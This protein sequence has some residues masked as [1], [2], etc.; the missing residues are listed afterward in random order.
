MVTMV[1]TL[2]LQCLYAM[3]GRL[4]E[5]S[6][7]TLSLLP[8]S[9]KRQLLLRLPVVDICS[10]ER[11]EGFRNLDDPDQVW[12]ELQRERV[13]F[14]SLVLRDSDS[15]WSGDGPRPRPTYKTAKDAVLGELAHVFL[16]N[17]SGSRKKSELLTYYMYGVHVCRDMLPVR[18]ASYREHSSLALSGVMSLPHLVWAVPKRF[19]G[20]A[21]SHITTMLSRFMQYCQWYPKIVQLTE[22]LGYLDK[23]S[24][25]LDLLPYVE[26][27]YVSTD[28]PS[29]TPMVTT[30]LQAVVKAAQRS[31][32]SVSLTAYS[33][34]LYSLITVLFTALHSDDSKGPHL[35]RGLQKLELVVASTEGSCYPRLSW[36][37]ESLAQL[38][39]HQ[40]ALE[41]LVINNFLDVPDENDNRGELELIHSSY[42][43]FG[44]FFNFLPHFV[45]K[46]SFKS[47]H[48]T[49][50]RIPCNAMESM[51]T[52]LLNSP[53]SHDQ[54]LDFIGCYIMEKCTKTIT[55]DCGLQQSEEFRL[56]QVAEGRCIAGEHKSL[57]V[58]VGEPLFPLQWLAD[59]PGLRL[60]RLDLQ[61]IVPEDTESQ[62]ARF[63]ATSEALNLFHQSVDT[64]C[65]TVL[66]AHH[67]SQGTVSRVME[68]PYLKELRLINC[69]YMA[70]D[71]ILSAM[72]CAIAKAN[73]LRRL[74]FENLGTSGFPVSTTSHFQEFFAALFT[75][76]REQLA[77]FELDFSSMLTNTSQV[78]AI[79][80]AWTLN[81]KNQKL[82][83]ITVA[84]T[85]TNI[86]LLNQT[87]VSLY[88]TY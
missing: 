30:Q 75:M 66:G 9:L 4:E 70:Q 28:V 46:P 43:H 55:R 45:C 32:K 56:Y 37:T 19:A 17:V 26:E 78:T 29:R 42:G 64:L 69:S 81:S 76:P 31:L 60:K 82:H 24:V 40:E 38:I 62:A 10:L 14:I 35:Y 3:A 7:Q 63:S 23:L 51:V 67:C 88:S 20:E 47:L 73:N 21:S 5:Y 11:D 12:R 77:L 65:V 79:H 8:T 15:S 1:P 18:L 6:S 72:T 16:A 44:R 36:A 61:L 58:P 33:S 86:A 13:A 2:Q 22:R 59:Y 57:S 27:L 25:Y 83:S 87:A 50:C 80:K 85:S 39:S 68:N 74:Q 41:S 84:K 49:A 52:A 53:T 48:V 71:G 54:Y 34:D